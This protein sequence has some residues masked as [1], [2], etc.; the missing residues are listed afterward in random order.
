MPNSFDTNARGPSNRAL[1]VAGVC[2]VVVAALCVALAV[3]KSRRKLDRFVRVSAELVNVGD[4]PRLCG[5][6]LRRA[7]SARSWHTDR[8]AP[9]GP[10]ATALPRNTGVFAG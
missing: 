4:F 9:I 3:A 5:L 1:F 8:C 2:V 7:R 10:Y 6:L